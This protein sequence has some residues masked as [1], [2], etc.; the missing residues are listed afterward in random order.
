MEMSNLIDGNVISACIS[1]DAFMNAPGESSIKEI[2]PEKATE[3]I[4]TACKRCTDVSAAAV[5]H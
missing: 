1:K 4:A 5:K 2:F 3:W